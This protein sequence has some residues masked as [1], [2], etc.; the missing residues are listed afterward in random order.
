MQNF[1][2]TLRCPD[3][4]G[5]THAITGALLDTGANILP[6]AQSAEPSDGALIRADFC[7]HRARGY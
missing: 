4:P 2:L 6:Q 5:I 7:W 3:G 1:I